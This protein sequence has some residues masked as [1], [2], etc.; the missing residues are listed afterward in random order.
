MARG[1]A[2]MDPDKKR[3]I[4]SLGGKAAQRKGTGH[5]WTPEEAKHYGRKGGF[6]RHGIKVD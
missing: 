4:Q 5:K 6:A 1:F 2:L 3:A